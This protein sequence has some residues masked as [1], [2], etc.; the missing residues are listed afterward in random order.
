M[1]W[2]C[3]RIHPKKKSSFGCEGWLH[4]DRGTGVGEVWF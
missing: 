1:R 4:T 2:P 3:E